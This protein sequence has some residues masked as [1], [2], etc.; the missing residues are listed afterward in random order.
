MLL[1]STALCHIL[2]LGV[3]AAIYFA[4]FAIIVTRPNAA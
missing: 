4:A 3:E 1:I 2:G